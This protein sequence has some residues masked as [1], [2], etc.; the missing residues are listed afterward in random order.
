MEA[1]GGRAIGEGVRGQ[2]SGVRRQGSGVRGAEDQKAD[3]GS[4]SSPLTTH[5]SPLTILPPCRIV[6]DLTGVWIVAEATGRRPEPWRGPVSEDPL[7]RLRH[8]AGVAGR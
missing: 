2:E 8:L 6:E 4:L 7:A 5:H 3:F 1:A